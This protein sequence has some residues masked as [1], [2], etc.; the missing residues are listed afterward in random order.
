MKD[1]STSVNDGVRSFFGA[2]ENIGVLRS[3]VLGAAKLGIKA[4]IIC[5]GIATI[6]YRVGA[7]NRKCDSGHPRN[8]IF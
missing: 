8:I 7:V 5:E 3:T 1:V 4:K 2:I 6:E